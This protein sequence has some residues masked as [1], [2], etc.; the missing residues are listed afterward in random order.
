MGSSDNP[1]HCF[2]GVDFGNLAQKRR[3]E[4]ET[5]S[6]PPQWV[7]AHSGASSGDKSR[8]ISR[9]STPP[10]RG[11]S[12]PEDAVRAA[13]ASRYRRAPGLARATGSSKPEGPPCRP[14]PRSSPGGQADR[15][16]RG[17]SRCGRSRTRSAARSP[18]PACRPAHADCETST[19]L[20]IATANCGDGVHVARNL[21][22]PIMSASSLRFARELSRNETHRRR[23]FTFPRRTANRQR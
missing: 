9:R 2:G 4:G 12:A 15:A 19:I 11:G 22:S 1:P 6:A 20:A 16:P 13:R 23:I 3:R 18:R 7:G 8:S 10:P 14:A 17:A 21:R 5:G